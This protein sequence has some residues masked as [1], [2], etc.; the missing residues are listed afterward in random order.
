MF[1]CTTSWINPGFFRRSD[2][3]CA[4]LQVLSSRI[5]AS[6]RALVPVCSF[7]SVRQVR[8][9]L[10]SQVIWLE[11]GLQNLFLLHAAQQS[12]SLGSGWDRTDWRRLS[13]HSVA[14]WQLFWRTAVGLAALLISPYYTGV[15]IGSEL[16]GV[17]KRSS[18]GSRLQPA[19]GQRTLS[20]ATT[21]WSAIC[22][23]LR[24]SALPSQTSRTCGRTAAVRP[25]LRVAVMRRTR[26]TAV[27]QQPEGQRVLSA[28]R[29]RASRLL[30]FVGSRPQRVAQPV[31]ASLSQAH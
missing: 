23:R 1:R 18:R 14:D 13:F 20:R 24:A 29:A 7:Q 22:L 4:D 19:A 11:H 16:R 12:S 30:Y 2:W 27:Q 3:A 8:R 17:Q 26:T 31:I 15:Q 9:S 10:R 5:Q 28:G 25:I 6:R 21:A